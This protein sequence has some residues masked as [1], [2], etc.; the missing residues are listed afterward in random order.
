MPFET[1]VQ[2]ILQ[3]DSLTEIEMEAAL[4]DVIPRLNHDTVVELALYLSLESKFN[5]K[6]VWRALEA[7]AY[8]SFHL[9]TLKQV[10]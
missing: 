1:N 6:D 8:E 3:N 4:L 7:A 2:A 10:C 9:L 5:S